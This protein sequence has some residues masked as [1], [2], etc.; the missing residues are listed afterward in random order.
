MTAATDVVNGLRGQCWRA[1]AVRVAY[2]RPEILPSF[3]AIEW[4]PA[5]ETV[6]RDLCDRYVSVRV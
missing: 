1:V 6:A 3:A 5:G 2:D 4:A